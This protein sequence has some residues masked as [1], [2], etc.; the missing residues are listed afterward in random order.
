[1]RYL[2]LFLI[3]CSYTVYSQITIKDVDQLVRNINA[4]KETFEKKELSNSNEGN[5]YV[6]LQDEEPRIVMVNQKDSVEKNVTWYFLDQKLLYSE[7]LWTDRETN[8]KLYEE[9]TYHDK[10]ILFAWLNSE[11]KFKD[12]NSIEFKSL[13]RKLQAYSQELL[14]QARE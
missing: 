7:T 3:I 4:K 13:D 6:W 9:K 1:M 11:N 10:G 12:A 5:S 2:P 8:K 14:I